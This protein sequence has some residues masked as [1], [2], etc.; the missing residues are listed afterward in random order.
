[1]CHFS[2]GVEQ[3]LGLKDENKIIDLT[4]A[5]REPEDLVCESSAVIFCY[6]F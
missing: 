4:S 5:N 3:K 2:K 1:M 6:I